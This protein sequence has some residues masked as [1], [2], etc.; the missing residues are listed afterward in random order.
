MANITYA[1]IA[2]AGISRYGIDVQQDYLNGG[3]TGHPSNGVTIRNVLFQ[4]VTGT[5]AATARNYYVLCGEG[6]CADFEFRDVRVTGGG[7]AS[8]CNYPAGGCPS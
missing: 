5:A 6:S 4:N 8:S 1:N 2:L 3:P 7:V